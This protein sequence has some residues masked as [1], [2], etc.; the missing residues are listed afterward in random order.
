MDHWDITYTLFDG[1]LIA[2]YNTYR[3][4]PTNPDWS[5]LP[6]EGSFR[7]PT[8][9]ILY[10]TEWLGGA[11]FENVFGFFDD[12]LLLSGAL[13]FNYDNRSSHTVW[14]TPQ[15][16]NPG[17][18]YV[19]DPMP[20]NINEKVTTRFGLVYKL[21]EKV[22]VY[23]GSTEAFLAVGAIFKADGGRLDPETGRN[24]EIGL[25]ADLFEALG[26]NISFT[27]ALFQINVVNKWRGDPQNPGFFIQDGE[28]ESKGMDMQLT[29]SSE[30]L[31]AIMG[32]FQAEGPTDHLTG[33]RAVIVPESTWNFWGK[34]RITPRLSIGGGYKSMGNTLA[35]NRAYRTKR[36]G[37]ADLFASYEHPV[38]IGKMVYR[39][40]ISNL[41]DNAA[42]FRMNSAATVWREE[43]R[44][45][46]LT[47]SY[48]W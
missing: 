2:P 31:S 45:V 5:L 34:Y 19:G 6:G 4:D 39:A 1:H 37:T 16:Q 21:S 38:R 30:K 8:R 12:R 35:N 36:Y 15:N 47:V 25:K 10:N 28:Q 17:G 22:S 46:K 29:Y 48:I 44:R 14:R 11:V 41:T 9:Y 43:G 27:G 23:A 32:Y 40:G 42:V 13:R 20:T 18:Q 3:L 24:Q 7:S 26:G 33:E